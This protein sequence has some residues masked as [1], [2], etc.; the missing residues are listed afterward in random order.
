MSLWRQSVL[1]T[2]NRKFKDKVKLFLHMRNVQKEFRVRE[3]KMYR[4]YYLWSNM[5]IVI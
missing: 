3:R 5:K 2:Y 1:F 4:I